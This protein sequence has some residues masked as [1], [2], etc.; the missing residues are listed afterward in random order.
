MRRPALAGNSN[1]VTGVCRNAGNSD[2][3]AGVCRNEG[4]IFQVVT[5]RRIIPV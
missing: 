4:N 5:D 3:I 1:T 2:T